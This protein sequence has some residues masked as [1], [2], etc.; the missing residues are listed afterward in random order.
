MM[1]LL[2]WGVA[3]VAVIMAPVLALYASKLRKVKA[4]YDE[5]RQD[6]KYA[7]AS[8]R[9]RLESQEAQVESLT[10]TVNDSSGR[11]KWLWG[12]VLGQERRLAKTTEATLTSLEAARQT[13]DHT[14][15]MEGRLK[16]LEVDFGRSREAF[17]QLE[18]IESLRREVSALGG[19]AERTRVAVGVDGATSSVP[20]GALPTGD[21]TLARLT[22][23]ELQ[24]V[25]VLAGEGAK[26]SRELEKVTGRTREHT[27]RVMKKLYLE[28]YVDRDT[29]KLPYI[30]RLNDKLKAAVQKS[31]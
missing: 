20:P 21:S 19:K 29:H 11:V 16:Q 18:E 2:L 13:L 3:A 22:E 28:G 10:R 5:V 4:E 9:K 1:D 25:Q 30:Y 24:V 27:A 12:R 8:Y 23:T 31:S 14:L 6:L 17:K 7:F 15:A 26:T